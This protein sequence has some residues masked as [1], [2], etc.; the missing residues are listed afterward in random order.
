MMQNDAGFCST[1]WRHG[2]AAN[3]PYPPN[4]HKQTKKRNFPLG[5]EEVGIGTEQ[6]GIGGKEKEQKKKSL[7]GKRLKK[8]EKA[9]S[10]GSD[11]SLLSFELAYDFPPACEDIPIDT[12]S[13]ATL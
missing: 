2:K 13:T 8:H 11:G 10:D 1:G 12:F 6:V 9:I 5:K 4:T 3:Q 7:R